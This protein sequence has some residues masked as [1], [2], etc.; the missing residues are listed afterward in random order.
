MAEGGGVEVRSCRGRGVVVE[1]CREGGRGVERKS[2]G[3]WEV[4]VGVGGSR[5]GGWEGAGT[6]GKN[7][8]S[9]QHQ[10]KR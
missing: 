2:A 9:A 1:R 3:R 6:G 5:G 4:G 8:S 7:S 10:L